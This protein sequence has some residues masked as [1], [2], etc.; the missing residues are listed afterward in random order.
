MPLEKL[1][2]QRPQQTK[3]ISSFDFKIS[4]LHIRSYIG[5]KTFRVGGYLLFDPYK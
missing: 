5:A 1:C 3:A 2:Q 4:E